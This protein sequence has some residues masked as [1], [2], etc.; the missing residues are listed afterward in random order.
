MFYCKKCGFEFHTP[1]KI[2]ESHGL[3]SPPFEEIRAC[4]NCKSLSIAVKK[5]T[6]CRCC[7]ARLKGVTDCYCSNACR[8]KGERLYA[9]EQKRR[10]LRNDSPINL[11]I[12]KLN[13]YNATNGT[14]LS[15]GQYVALILPKENTEKCT[16]TKKHI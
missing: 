15:Y 12:K 14:N 11:I 7:G 8:E 1:Q 5:T 4:P 6:H 13:C 3:G 9:L 2:Y 16:K 10:H